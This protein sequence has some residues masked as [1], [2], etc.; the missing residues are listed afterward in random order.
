MD[1]TEGEYPGLQNVVAFRLG[2]QTYAL[3]IEPIVQ[4]I[5]M[6]AITPIPQLDAVIE[7][8]INVRGEAAAVV[9]LRR[10]FDLP[11]TP[12]SLNTPILLVQ[13]SGLTIGLI[14]DE[15]TDVLN[16]STDQVVQLA[17]ILPEELGNAPIFRGLTYVSDDA[18]LMLDHESLFRP[19]QLE[20]LARAADLLQETITK[21]GRVKPVALPTAQPVAQ[22]VAEPE[23][24]PTAESKPTRT[25]KATPKKTSASK[26]TR[27]KPEPKA[28]RKRG[29]SKSTG[30]NA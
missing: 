13:I 7:G 25:H 29:K 2:R 5:D 30:G 6:V 20:I 28:T 21:K 10:H 11:D 1:A 23:T 8:V 27:A 9:K 15:V 19:D 18:V 12:L 26:K 16:L 24:K 4:I 14:V 22:P 17:E 3:P